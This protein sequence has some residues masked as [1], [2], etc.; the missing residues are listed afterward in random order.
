MEGRNIIKAKNSIVSFYNAIEKLNRYLHA[1]NMEVQKQEADPA[2]E[3][4]SVIEFLFE[5]ENRKRETPLVT[6]VTIT[7]NLIKAGRKD[8]VRQCIRSVH[9]QTYDNIEHLIIDGASDDGTLKLLENYRKR[10]WI[11]IFSEPDDGLYD[12]MN[13]GISR[14][15]GKYIA[16]LNSDDFYH[17]TCGVEKTVCALQ[18]LQADYAFSDTNILNEDGSVYY[19]IA[20]I[21]NIL[22]ARNYCHQSMFT[23]LNVMKELN[24]FDL[25]YRVSADSDLMIRLY[26]REYSYVNV[27]YCFVTYRG[28]GLSAAAAEESR[29]DHSHSFF[30]HLGQKYSLTHYDCYELWQYRFFDELSEGHQFRLIAKI[31]ECFNAEMIMHE[32]VRRRKNEEGIRR[33]IKNLIAQRVSFDRFWLSRK[34]RI[35][36]GKQEMIYYFCKILPIWITKEK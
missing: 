32:Y 22:Y 12:A 4:T 11:D 29:R 18:K 26:N 23:R 24:G 1:G 19:W 31:P 8:S 2:S 9:N 6:I 15:N 36:N 33:Q 30:V 16:F 28:G 17:D 5:V 14:A 25:N 7:Y 10:G 21:R 34:L 27:P 35:R 20:D 13:K 3:E